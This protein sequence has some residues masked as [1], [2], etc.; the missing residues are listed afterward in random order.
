MTQ[1]KSIKKLRNSLLTK[2]KILD[3][4]TQYILSNGFKGLGMNAV[5]KEAGVSKML[6]YRYFTNM[7]GLIEAFI[8]SGRLTTIFKPERL[9]ELEQMNPNERVNIWAR[10]LIGVARELR[11]QQLMKA[12]LLWELSENNKVLTA[13]TA[14][15]NEQLAKM[16]TAS[17][18]EWGEDTAAI[19]AILSAGIVYLALAEDKRKKYADL[20]LTNDEVWQRIENALEFIYAAINNTLNKITKK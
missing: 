20:D 18:T 19:T 6:I 7:D 1:K 11:Q 16:I 9:A 8:L 3:S 13:F 5:A 14:T 10:R 4:L 15:R 2:Q 17:A 12:M